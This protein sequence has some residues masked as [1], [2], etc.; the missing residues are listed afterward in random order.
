MLKAVRAIEPPIKHQTSSQPHRLLSLA[1]RSV[2][3]STARA[4]PHPA[5]LSLISVRSFA[6][7]NKVAI[8][9]LAKPEPGKEAEKK[10][11]ILDGKVLAACVLHL[12]SQNNLLKR[13]P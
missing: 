1:R 8:D 5:G 4:S 11:K 10:G 9:Q 13:R 6:M 2:R 12:S 7:S 3:P